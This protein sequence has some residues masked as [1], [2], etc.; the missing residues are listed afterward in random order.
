MK[1]KI[2]IA[3]VALLAVALILLSVFN[4]GYRYREGLIQPLVPDTVTIHH[5]DTLRVPSPPDT[6][7][8]TEYKTVQVPLTDVEV[9]TDVDSARITLPFEQHFASLDSVADIWY[10]GYQ[11]KIDSAVVY[12]RTVTQIIKQPY[13]VMNVKMPRATLD[14]GAAAFYNGERINTCLVGEIRWNAPKTTFSA[15][16]AVDPQG[17]WAAGVGVTY[18]INLIK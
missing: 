18:R 8:K 11:A 16:G 4:A 1:R 15:F 6:V 2:V 3:L 17:N 14:I 10:S 12:K 9:D 7:T 5:T 13:E